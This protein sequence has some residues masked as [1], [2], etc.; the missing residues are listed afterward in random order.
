MTGTNVKVVIAT[1]LLPMAVVF[2]VLASSSCATDPETNVRRG[3]Q[4]VSAGK[5]QDAII[6][7]RTAIQANARLGTARQKLAAAYEKVGDS[8][9][10][11]REYIRAADLLPD[12]IHAQIKASQ[13]L[14][15]TGQFQDARARADRALVLDRNNTDAQIARGNAL[16]GLR[17][18]ESAVAEVEAAI[19]N[20]PSRA[21]TFSLLATMEASRGQFESAEDAF[22]KA[23]SLDPESTEPHIALAN[24]YLTTNR[25]RE[26]EATLNAALARKPQ[27]PVAL[28]A[29]IALYYLTDRA[30]QAEPLLKRHIELTSDPA[31]RLV[32]ADRYLA[33]RREADGMAMLEKLTT[34]SDAKLRSASMIRLAEVDADNG[35]RP[36]AHARLEALLKLQPSNSDALAVQAKLY[37]ADGQQAKALDVAQRAVQLAPQSPRAHHALG[38]VY[39]AAND[40]TKAIASMNEALTLDIRANTVRID[41]AR[42][43]VSVGNYQS[44]IQTTRDALQFDAGNPTARLLLATALMGQGDLSAAAAD[45]KRLSAEFP[46]SAAIQTRYGQVLQR[47]GD[48]AGAAAAYERAVAADPLAVEALRGLAARDIQNKKPDAARLR[49]DR[50]VAA[51]PT[52]ADA[53]L[54][55]AQIYAAAG[56][57]KKTEDSLKRVIDVDPAR[58]EA[59]ARLAQLYMGQSRLDEARVEFER[60]AKVGTREAVAANTM[61]GTIFVLQKKTNEAKARY[62]AAVDLD[63]RAAVAANNLAVLYSESGQNLNEAL[64]L[65]QSAKAVL[66]NRA[67]I[68]D[69]LGWI[70]Y[71]RGLTSQAISSLQH[72]TELAPENAE[73]RYRLAQAYVKANRHADARQELERALKTKSPFA[74]ADQAR[75]MLAKLPASGTVK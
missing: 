39:A 62:K 8:A 24:F 17:D 26:A 65:A 13:I 71:Q 34:V 6:E 10:A 59:F 56:D 15:A 9:S 3:D 23:I 31:L 49:A 57:A 43:Y 19:A 33:T 55:A 41:L 60:L 4:Y 27:D 48:V 2:G 16:A 53:L 21:S 25:R 5:Y 46:E 70:Y 64:Q 18:I 73:Y 37:L 75:A 68:D 54:A 42:L 61:L 7:Y 30:D 45:L 74:S 20:D 32:L 69:T 14:S 63:E 72:A 29:L 52:N 50:L 35:R 67:E 36:D 22:K 47:R 1:R 12:D 51:A 38:L 40:A 28:R 11:A 44:A 58:P 66:P